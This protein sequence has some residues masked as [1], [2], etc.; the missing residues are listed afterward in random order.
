MEASALQTSG[1]NGSP[2]VREIV[3]FIVA[4]ELFCVDIMNVREIRGWT[5]PTPLPH[6]PAYLRGLINLRG[7]VLPIV[8]LGCRLGLAQGPESSRTVIIVVHV[9]TQTV[10]LLVEGVSDILTVGESEIRAAPV[11]G[12]ENSGSYIRGIIAI[13]DR[14]IRLLDLDRMFSFSDLRKS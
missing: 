14:M 2:D 8:D 9:Q 5:E 1:L 11:L 6:A 4:D 7:A 10:G 13:G 12:T 3:T